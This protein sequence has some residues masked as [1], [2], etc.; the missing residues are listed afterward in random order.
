[1]HIQVRRCNTVG[2]LDPEHEVS[3]LR[4]TDTSAASCFA[5]AGV[6]LCLHGNWVLL[7]ALVSGPSGQYAPVMATLRNPV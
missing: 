3:L 6:H 7:K 4:H 2:A 5:D 1:M